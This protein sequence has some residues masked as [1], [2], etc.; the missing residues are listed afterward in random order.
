MDKTVEHNHPS[1]AIVEL[2]RLSRA[3]TD[4]LF[5]AVTASRGTVR[6]SITPAHMYHDL[7]SDHI[8]TVGHTPIVEVDMTEAQIGRLLSSVGMG[9]GVPCTIRRLQGKTIPEPPASSS[10][11]ERI[12]EA[13][14]EKMHSMAK[15]L[16]GHLPEIMA[17]LNK[18][19]AINKGDRELLKKAFDSIHQ[20]LA[21]NAEF[22]LQTFQESAERVVE[23]SKMEINIY[24]QKVAKNLGLAEPI[25]LKI[26]G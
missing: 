11:Q 25:V 26:G 22:A 23:A 21:N 16:R 17:I 12:Q 10:E 1:F 7:G 20:E 9:E 19:G 13:F 4:V 8:S 14:E 3:Y 24:A 2:S 15:D 18:D 6:L 5:G